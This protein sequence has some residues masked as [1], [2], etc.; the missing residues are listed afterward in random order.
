MELATDAI[1]LSPSTTDGLTPEVL[2]A[3]ENASGAFFLAPS[4]EVC[5]NCVRSV[6]EVCAKCDRK[7]LRGLKDKM[8]Q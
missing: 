2:L 4:D 6:S 1:A 8:V 3:P 5:T 7:S